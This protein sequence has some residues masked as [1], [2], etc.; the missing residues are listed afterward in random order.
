[1]RTTCR[2]RDGFVA[3]LLAGLVVAVL[4]LFYDLGQRAPLQTPAFLWAAVTRQAFTVPLAVSIIGFVVIHFL[5]WGGLGTFAAFSIRWLNLPLDVLLGTT[6]G[7]LFASLVFYLGISGT[8]EEFVFS[9]PSWPAVLFVNGV[10][11]AVMFLQMER[12]SVQLDLRGLIRF[13]KPSEVTRQGLYTGLVGGSV[14]GVWFLILDTIVREPLYTPATLGMI[15]F[16]GGVGTGMG[17]VDVTLMPALGYGLWHFAFFLIVGVL[18]WNHFDGEG[19]AQFLFLQLMCVSIALDLSL[20]VVAVLLENW[21]LRELT[22]WAIL[23]GNGLAAV[24]MGGY[25]LKR[26]PYDRKDLRLGNL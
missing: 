2:V 6:F 22:W 19:T 3:G 8:P 14:V 1:M 18:M 10:G 7:L 4:F 26:R 17:S 11:G 25:L 5:A 23:I 9:A 15:L 21:I 20:I 12:S 13:F 24:A 16:Q